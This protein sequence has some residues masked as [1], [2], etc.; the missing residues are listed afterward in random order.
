MVLVKSTSL[1]PTAFQPITST[2]FSNLN[3]FLRYIYTGTIA[4]DAVNVKNNLIELLLAADGMNL[5]ELVEHPQQYII[6]L[7]LD[8]DWIVQNGV[9]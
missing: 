1:E 5:Y 3:F 4:L 2:T 8:N 6:H 9:I 7:S